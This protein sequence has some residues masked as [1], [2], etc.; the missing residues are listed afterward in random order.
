MTTIASVKCKLFTL[1]SDEYITSF[2]FVFGTAN[3][4]AEN[5]VLRA[6]TS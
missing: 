4:D 5:G 6:E 3:A 1:R 2:T